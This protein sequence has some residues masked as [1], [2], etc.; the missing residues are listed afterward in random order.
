MPEHSMLA[1][2]KKLKNDEFYTQYSDIQKEINAYIEYNPDVF[3]DKTVLLPCDD[4]EWS[5]FTKFFAQNFEIFGLKK[6]I[7][8]SY[9]ANSKAIKG[10]YQPTLFET[11]SDEFDEKKTAS[12][13]KIFTLSRDEGN[14]EHLDI[15]NLVWHYLEGDGDFRSNEVKKL[16]DEADFIITNPPFSKFR[17][18]LT[19]IL[20]AQKQFL[21]I[22]NINCITYKEV[23]PRIQSNEIWL[24]NG[25]GR[26]ISGFIVPPEYE[27][28]GT[29]AKINEEGQ[30]IVA[31]NNCLWLTNIDHGR[32]HQ[33]LSLMTM[34]EN[35]RYSK[36][37]EI[38][39]QNYQK[40]DN[41]DAIEVPFTDAIPRDYDGAMGVPITFLDKYNPEQFEILG[42]SYSYASPVCHIPGNDYGTTIK[43]KDVYKRLFIRRKR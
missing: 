10:F 21:I 5:N 26:W 31:T 33:P 17:E 13:G 38:H 28:Y 14:S 30:R 24:G 23:F 27:L 9:A 34:E 22:G 8:T 37:K 11:I 43:G 1:K 40:Y 36:H 41:Y 19:W 12:H 39:G 25:M 6:L 4:P 7:S 16:R 32:R 42:C 29:E 35:I 20:E 15:N 18:F 2:A 3:R